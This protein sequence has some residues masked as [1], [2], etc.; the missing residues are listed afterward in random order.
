MVLTLSVSS[1]ANSSAPIPLS[2]GRCKYAGQSVR[3]V[4]IRILWVGKKRSRGVQLV[5]DEYIGKLKHY[6]SVEDVQIRSNPKN[7]RDWRA[8]VDD[9]DN[10]V[11]NLIRSDDWVVLLDEGGRDIRSE[12]MAELL[13]D[14]GN[15]GASRLSFC[16]GGP[17][18]HGRLLR[19]RANKSIKLSSMVFNHQI[20]LLVLVEQLYRS[21]TILKGQKYHH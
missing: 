1:L 11:V 2:G 6:C 7:A 16:I 3:A 10:A 15:T 17:Y 12:Q 9:E 4:P 5:F 8:Q 14:A 19:E 13:G 18:G 21:W 20:A